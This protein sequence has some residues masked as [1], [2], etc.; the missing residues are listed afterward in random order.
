VDDV[1]LA[2]YV[3]GIDYAHVEAGRVDSVCARLIGVRAG[4]PIWFSD[5]TLLKLT[6]K[7]GE[8]TFQHYRY[9]PKLL[10]QGFLARSRKP[11]HLELWWLDEA[12]ATPAAL[13]AVIKATRRDELFVGTFHPLHRPE[14]RRLV[15]KAS[16]EARL[17]RSQRGH[18]DPS[19]I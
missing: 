6:Q 10:L 19:N 9:M 17:I 2:N 15:R 11:R 3:L 18:E 14:A 4:T 5:Y 1:A 8:I 13:F 12:D 16:R 7:H